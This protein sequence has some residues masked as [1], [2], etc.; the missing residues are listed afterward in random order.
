MKYA[1]IL[2]TGIV[3]LLCFC[4]GNINEV[5]TVEGGGTEI[6][7]YLITADAVPVANATVCLY[8]DSTDTIKAVTNDSGKY[9]FDTRIQDGVYTFIGKK[10]TLQCRKPNRRYEQ[11]YTVFIDTLWR[12]GWVYATVYLENNKNI[13]GTEAY[14]AGTSFSGK[15]DSLGNIL[16]WYVPPGNY[17]IVFQRIG[18]VST[19]SIINVIS[20]KID[21]V[22]LVTLLRNESPEPERPAELHAVI[23]SVTSI[24]T[25][26]WKKSV[27]RNFNFFEIRVIDN[28]N[29]EKLHEYYRDTIYDALFCDTV[30][31][32]NFIDTTTYKFRAY[33]V[34]QMTTDFNDSKWSTICSLYVPK[35]VTPPV[36]MCT[37]LTVSNILNVGVHAD[38]PE[39]C[40]IDTLFINRTILN[41]TTTFALGYSEYIKHGFNDFLN[42]IPINSDS[43]YSV[44]YTLQTKSIYNKK[45]S[46]SNVINTSIQNPY[47]IFTIK[48]P[49]APTGL[50]SEGNSDVSYC[51]SLNPVPA[52]LPDDTTEYRIVFKNQTDTTVTVTKWYTIPV[53]ETQFTRTGIYEVM[54]Q[55]RSRHLYNLVS[56]TSKSA[57]I[58]INA[59]HTVPRPLT[60]ERLKPDGNN[61]VN[62]SNPYQ[63]TVKCIDTCSDGHSLS[64]RYFITYENESLRDSTDWK[65][66]SDNSTTI[67]WSKPGIGYLR[68]QARCNSFPD[69]LSPWSDALVVTIK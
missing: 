50:P 31:P 60:P 64:V 14:L 23:D 41:S 55:A 2:L 1:T 6:T 62:H 65:P 22:P 12:P 57:A 59:I 49:D 39:L 28:I 17:K 30:Y 4:S 25:L 29:R 26:N 68:A 16:F 52:P 53:I 48:T 21:S 67:V 51:V 43:T 45:S 38:I 54:C 32:L 11:P 44:S 69:I 19:S 33:Q 34:K 9:T 7:G 47:Q 8:N 20:N 61:F 18:Y 5:H 24:V 27:T 37:H 56:E 10:D 58:K 66:L 3:I 42:S 13:E 35:P 46:L 63:Y 36:P 40:W 15:T